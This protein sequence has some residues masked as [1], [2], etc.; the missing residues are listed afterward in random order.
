MAENERTVQVTPRLKYFISKPS[1]PIIAPTQTSM[2]TASN[3]LDLED[4]EQAIVMAES[5]L[6]EAEQDGGIL[7]R[8][9]DQTAVFRIKGAFTRG[10]DDATAEQERRALLTALERVLATDRGLIMLTALRSQKRVIDI[11]LIPGNDA[12]HNLRLN[13]DSDKGIAISR[14]SMIIDTGGREETVTAPIESSLAHELGHNIMEAGDDLDTNIIENE[15]PILQQLLLPTKIRR[16]RGWPRLD[17][18]E[19]DRRRFFDAK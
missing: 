14:D 10:A 15:N 1:P 12:S 17:A 19:S 11:E 4:G 16:Q 13:S 3:A 6:T 2:T 7:V 18:P 5:L 8:D 9:L